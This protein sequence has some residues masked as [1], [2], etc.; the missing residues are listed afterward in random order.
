[1]Q[2]VKQILEA[3]AKLTSPQICY[4]RFALR[5]LSSICVCVQVCM[6]VCVACY[7]GVHIQLNLQA[8][9]TFSMHKLGQTVS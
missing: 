5:P 7:A 4:L 9:T 3:F 1:M 6:C 2:R 8:G